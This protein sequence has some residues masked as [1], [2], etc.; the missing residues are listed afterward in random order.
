MNKEKIIKILTDKKVYFIGLGLLATV[1]LIQLYFLYSQLHI[2]PAIGSCNVKGIKLQGNLYTYRNYASDSTGQSSKDISSSEEITAAIEK[3]NKDNSIKAI[4]LEVDSNGGQPV[5]GWEI[6]EALKHSS[7]PTVAL[8][9]QEGDSAAYLASTGAKHIIAAAES[10]VGDIGVTMSYVGNYDKNTND[11]LTFY[12][13]NEGQFKD[14]GNPDA[15]LTPEAQQMFMRNLKISYDDFI[16]Y[17]SENRH[18]DTAKVT[19]L[20]NGAAMPGQMAKDN[21]L[22]DQVGGIYDA[23]AYLQKQIKTNVNICW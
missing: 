8:I 11:G 15:P 6:M 20:A 17:V 2:L 5:A 9:R 21:G 7:K 18:L 16:K 1:F 19:A 14:A 3:A 12:Q 23:E 10:D 13:L 22:I 4:L